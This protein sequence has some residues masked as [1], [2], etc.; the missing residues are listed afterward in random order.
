MNHEESGMRDTVAELPGE[1][2][3]N[4]ERRATQGLHI[5]S[6]FLG[7]PNCLPLALPGSWLCLSPKKAQSL[8][9]SPPKNSPDLWNNP[10]AAIKDS[11][12]KQ[13][14]QFQGS[15][16]YRLGKVEVWTQGNT[17][18]TEDEQQAA[19]LTAPTKENLCLQ[20]RHKAQLPKMHIRTTA[21][22]VSPP[23]IH[24]LTSSAGFV[25]PWNKTQNS[26]GRSS[27]LQDVWT[28]SITIGYLFFVV[29]AGENTL[30]R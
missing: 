21:P 24:F 14:L 22:P 27:H 13:A 5:S 26:V 4:T 16:T 25:L 7:F 15:N 10:Q 28:I 9:L 1:G 2:N 12:K 19:E 20:S 11:P 6:H 30:L 3:V 17:E 18:P 29:P 23:H 8:P